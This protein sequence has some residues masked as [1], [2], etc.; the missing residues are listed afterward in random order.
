MHALAKRQQTQARTLAPKPGAEARLLEIYR[1]I[2]KGNARQALLAA[3]SLALDHP[4]FKL[5][6]LVR[7]DL[8]LTMAGRAKQFGD[9]T[10]GG[11]PADIPAVRGEA[12]TPRNPRAAEGI[13]NN[14]GANLT[15][16]PAT[17][18]ELRQE[19]EL[20]VAALRERPASDAV[21]AAFIELGS[22]VR[23]A[24]LVDLS[25]SRLYHYRQVAGKLTLD[26]DYYITQGRL[27]PDKSFEGDQR[28]PLGVYFVTRALNR[29]AL[30]NFY[31]AGALPINFP[32]E[33][34]RRRNR[35]GSGIWLHGVPDGPSGTLS[36]APRASDG[37]VVLANN[38]LQRV[39]GHV[40]GTRPE[41]GGVLVPVVI[42]R[43]ATWV[44]PAQ[45]T[46]NRAPFDR[47]L[48]DW[49][50]ER[51]TPQGANFKNF[52]SFYFQSN[53]LP[54]EPWAAKAYASAPPAGIRDATVIYYPLGVGN[55][56][57]N[58][59]ANF[60]A[61]PVASSDAKL[62]LM[63]DAKQSTRQDEL[64]VVTYLDTEAR[65]K[66]TALVKKRQYW[67]KVNGR[68][69]IFFEGAI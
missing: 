23:D 35:T 8:L 69:Q 40:A 67:H 36:R 65:G 41:N 26:Q 64:L 66:R 34:D 44:T 3:D 15:L 57:A 54:F 52:Y 45:Q 49:Q 68:W 58:V 10:T 53:N 62:D 30:D 29:K 1:L 5:A 48:A 20:R 19:A 46:T 59:A 38:D 21:P 51:A 18:P 14:A 25:R 16:N 9:V 37:C 12:I 4:T 63:Q 13:T 43:R 32:N 47:L 27:G 60:V 24:F 28:T 50:R 42:T 31:G 61:T 22:N 11:I 55:S 39:L 2:G 17:L 6:H 7:G 33:F 56:A